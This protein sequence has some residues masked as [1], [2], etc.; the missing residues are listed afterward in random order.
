MSGRTKRSEPEPIPARE[1]GYYWVLELPNE[2]GDEPDIMFY[3]AMTMNDQEPMFDSS[4]KGIENRIVSEY[5]WYNGNPEDD[6]LEDSQVL[7]VSKKLTPFAAPCTHKEVLDIR[8]DVNAQWCKDCGAIAFDE[9]AD[10]WELPLN[11]K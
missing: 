1:E 7:V 2:E 9:T 5:S 6:C 10:Y 4:G 8:A 3:G 11:A